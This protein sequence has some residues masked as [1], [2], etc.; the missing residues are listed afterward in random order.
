MGFIPHEI[1]EGFELFE[2]RAWPKTLA[3]VIR[4]PE[5]RGPEV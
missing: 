5:W 1:S 3:L 2:K 4:S